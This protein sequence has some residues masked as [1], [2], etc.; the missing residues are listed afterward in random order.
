MGADGEIRAFGGKFVGS[1]SSIINCINTIRC[2]LK[3]G[4]I[5]DSVEDSIED[6]VYLAEHENECI[7]ETFVS[8]STDM[9]LVLLPAGEFDMGSSFEEKG[10]SDCESPVHRV[11][12]KNPFYIGKTQVTQRQ[13]KKI[14][15]TSPSNFKDE[16]RPVEMVSWEEIQEFIKILNEMEN[17]DKYRLPSEAEWEYACR[18][19]TQSRYFFGDDEIKIGEY[20][21]YTRNSGSKTHPVGKKKPNPWGL[22]DLNGNVW[23]WVQDSWHDNYAGAPSD[24][25]A[26]EDG[27]SSNRVS[28]GG[29]WYCDPDFCRSAARFSREPD[30]RLANLGLRLVREL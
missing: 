2:Y 23:E 15:G 6:S 1:K 28:R 19:G 27:D 22:Y 13:W 30:K 3:K 12:I 5:E 21:W 11:K 4:E 8:P 7:F 26:W 18:A 24:D 25:S 14:M 9:K 16:A 20:A 10:R 29:S 17:I